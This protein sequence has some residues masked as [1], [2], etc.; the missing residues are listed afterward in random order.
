MG[1][2]YWIVKNYDS[3][4]D[5]VIFAHGVHQRS[6]ILLPELLNMCLRKEGE[7]PKESYLNLNFFGKK[8]YI[9]RKIKSLSVDRAVEEHYSSLKKHGVHKFKNLKNITIHT[10]WGN[11][12]I[13]SR[14]II[15]QWTKSFYQISLEAATTGKIQQECDTCTMVY[16]QNNYSG[17][18]KF[19]SRHTEIGIYYEYVFDYIWNGGVIRTNPPSFHDYR[20]FFR[21]RCIP[22][23]RLYQQYLKRNKK[24]TSDTWTEALFGKH[25][26]SYE[27]H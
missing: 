17:S 5:Y 4:P 7:I 21:K 10:C 15:L 12:W 26:T 24:F 13:V 11:T 3:L 14:D 22:T 23:G 2:L 1:Y 16:N 8:R 18:V 25:V 20:T 9:S 6:F 27:S 19:N